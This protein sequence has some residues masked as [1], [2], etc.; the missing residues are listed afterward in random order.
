MYFILAYR[1]IILKLFPSWFAKSVWVA[2]FISNNS[3]ILFMVILLCGIQIYTILFGIMLFIHNKSQ[4][5]L[6]L[7]ISWR[8]SLNTSMDSNCMIWS[9][10]VSSILSVNIYT[11]YPSIVF[12]WISLITFGEYIDSEDVFLHV[13]IMNHRPFCLGV[14]CQFIHNII[15]YNHIQKFANYILIGISIIMNCH[16]QIGYII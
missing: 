14:F 4:N 13:R 6:C 5:K 12:I 16:N 8:E 3:L 10:A 2:P 7:S 1:L 11:L 15:R 9:R